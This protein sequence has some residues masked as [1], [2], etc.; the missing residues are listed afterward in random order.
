MKGFLLARQAKEAD[1]STEASNSNE[2]GAAKEDSTDDAAEKD[3]D[4]VNVK[5]SDEKTEAE[6]EERRKEQEEFIQTLR[7]NVNVFL[8]YMKSIESLDKDAYERIKKDEEEARKL[9]GYLWNTVLPALTKNVRLDN[10]KT[11]QIPVD[12]KGLTEF[13][14]Q[15]GVNCRYL[16][17][18]ADLARIEEQNDIDAE[19]AYEK[20][21]NDNKP[22]RFRMPLCWLEMLE[23]EMVAR[24]AKHVLDSYLTENGGIAAAQP[25]QTIASLL[26]AVVSIGEETASETEVRTAVAGDDAIDADEIN[27]LTL[28]GV[29]GSGDAVHKPVRGRA[30]IWADIEKEVGRRFRYTLTLYNQGKPNSRALYTPLLRRICQRSGIR[31][32]AKA[33]DIG[34]KCVCGGGSNSYPISAVDILDVLPLVK[35]AASSGDDA[36]TPCRFDG[37]NTSSLHI[38]FA[39]AQAIS[40]AANRHFKTGNLG[41]AADLA[42]EAASLY[43]RVIDS[44]LHE[45]IAKSLYLVSKCHLLGH[46]HEA[47]I[48]A[49]LKYLAIAVSIGGF[50]CREALEAHHQLSDAFISAGKLKEGIKHVRALLYLMEFVAGGNFT[51]LSA[52]YYKLGTQYFECEKLAE[53]L[54]F[55]DVAQKKRAHDC[56]V[57]GI[58]ASSSAMAYAHLGKFN[59]AS[60]EE[61]VAY[62]VYKSHLGEEHERTKISSS[63]LLVSGCYWFVIAFVYMQHFSD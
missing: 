5:K 14:H 44:P 26:S 31:L 52:I 47:A 62:Q 23:C 38:V 40:D 12:G 48:N 17:R 60:K 29:G 18:L 61:K 50:D 55:Y 32:V 41:L 21:K 1:K 36:F 10:F 16:G 58:I 56:M 37:N 27:A 8:P 25:A 63:H 54:E 42:Q 57:D 43:Q 30:E 20:N 3:K 6:I 19:K 35:H 49:S 28:F 15:H 34:K 2:K 22:P 4:W 9:A 53:A 51:Q 13:L 45:Q 24:A 46:D 11:I 7:Y 59:E 39:D 33:Y